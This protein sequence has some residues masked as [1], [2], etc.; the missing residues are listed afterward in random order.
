MILN[1]ISKLHLLHFIIV[2]FCFYLYSNG[3]D[4]DDHGYYN[5]KYFFIIVI[6]IQILIVLLNFLFS[7][8]KKNGELCPILVA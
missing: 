1:K 4:F 5:I 7:L 6:S 3:I 8:K 2:F